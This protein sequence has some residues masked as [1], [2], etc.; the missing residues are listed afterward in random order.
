M[1]NTTSIAWTDFTVNC[2]RGCR[3][4]SPGCGLCY[5]ERDDNRW[6]KDFTIVRP[7]PKGF[8]DLLALSR[9][10]AREHERDGRWPHGAKVFINSMTD[11]F[12]PEYDDEYVARVFAVALVC[13]NLTLQVLTKE[14]ARMRALLR[15]AAG[16][17]VDGGPRFSDMVFRIAVD[18]YGMDPG[19]DM[20]RWWP[21]PNVW[22]GV[23]VENQQFAKI[24]I[25][26]LLDCAAAVRWLSV[27]PMLG[28]VDLTPWMPPGLAAWEQEGRTVYGQ[29]LG[30]VVF[31]GESGRVHAKDPFAP[32]NES[33]MEPVFARPMDVAWVRNGVRQCRDAGVPAFV[34]QLGSVQ[35]T[36]LGLGDFK[37]EKPEEWPAEFDDLRVREFPLALGV[38]P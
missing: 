11:T 5:S 18:D 29:P 20:E 33:E 22:L 9:R 28:P 2:G 37:G 17:E 14:H 13:P 32:P 4:K 25:P 3:K 10:V 23:S 6:G 27:E 34:K 16:G 15:D 38:S 7:R 19:R 26:A 21:V 8:D 1:A 30:W 35:R 36:V 24:R 12:H 31:G